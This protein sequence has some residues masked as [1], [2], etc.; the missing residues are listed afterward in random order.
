MKISGYSR[1]MLGLCGVWMWGMSEAAEPY[2]V[3]LFALAKPCP[4]AFSVP[5]SPR[6]EVRELVKKAVDYITEHGEALALMAFSQSTGPFSRDGTYIFAIDFKGNMLAHG[7]EM[8]RIGQNY[9]DLKDAQ[10]RSVV[11]ALIEKGRYGKGAWVSYYWK[12]PATGLE[13]CKSSYVTSVNK[14]LIVGA[15]FHHPINAKG[16]CTMS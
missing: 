7:V 6:V 12:N 8:G 3:P 13:E 4:K 5:I 14:K 11:R 16:K 10:G 2:S 9:Y 1:A 15:G